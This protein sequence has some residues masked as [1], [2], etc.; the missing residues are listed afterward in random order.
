MERTRRPQQQHGVWPQ[1]IHFGLSRYNQL[2]AGGLAVDDCHGLTGRAPLGLW[3]SDLGRGCSWRWCR[4][5]SGSRRYGRWHRRLCAG[6]RRRR[7]GRSEPGSGGRGGRGVW[8]RGGGGGVSRG[9][10]VGGL[11]SPRLVDVVMSHALRRAV[12]TAHVLAWEHLRAP[13]AARV[14][15]SLEETVMPR[16]WARAL[17]MEALRAWRGL[18]VP[19]LA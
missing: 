13:Q 15:L 7:W 5:R 10:W 9:S 6:W 11:A 1:A 8:G 18:R 12:A 16:A 14:V 17:A 19:S 2:L 4:A 3:L